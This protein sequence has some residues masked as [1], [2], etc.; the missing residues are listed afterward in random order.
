MKFLYTG[1]CIKKPDYYYKLLR[2]P[3]PS[4]IYQLSFRRILSTVILIAT[5]YNEVQSSMA[6]CL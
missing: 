2:V 6:W 3:V 1:Q 5:W 4:V